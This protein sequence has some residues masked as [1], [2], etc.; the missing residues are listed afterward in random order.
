MAKKQKKAKKPTYA[1]L[2]QR[3]AATEQ[4]L[5]NSRDRASELAEAL[6]FYLQPLM[7]DQVRA[8]VEDAIDNAQPFGCCHF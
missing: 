2:E 6:Y 4:I 1:E 8:E 3:L 7:S 5:Q